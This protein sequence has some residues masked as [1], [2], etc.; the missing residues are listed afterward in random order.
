MADLVYPTEI[1][2]VTAF[3]CEP[4]DRRVLSSDEVGAQQVRG[5]ETD[6]HGTAMVGWEF[7]RA[8]LKIFRDWG[9]GD[10]EKWTRKFVVT[11][12]GYLGFVPHVAR[13]LRPPVWDHVGGGYWALN[14]ELELY[15]RSVN[16]Q[17]TLL[18]EIYP[19]LLGWPGTKT[20]CYI[21]TYGLEATGTL[22]WNTVPTPWSSTWDTWAGPSN[23]PMSYEHTVDLGSTMAVKLQVASDA[24][25]PAITEF[26]T[27]SDGVSYS[28]YDAVHA[29]T[30]TTRYIRVRWT[31]GG[32]I[33]VLY[34][35]TIT[36]QN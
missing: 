27:S 6:F 18:T 31:V 8:Q 36:V 26:R 33:P 10:L 17:Y 13:F 20:N 30:I 1:P 12:P 22:T 25:S 29:G 3:D 21:A 5:R 24:S 7:T 14:G 15:G 16:P 23:A 19:S 11:L 2:G 9:R 34:H 35:A 32:L 28:G 4:R